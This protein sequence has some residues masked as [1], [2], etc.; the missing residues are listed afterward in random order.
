LNISSSIESQDISRN[1]DFNKYQ[2]YMSILKNNNS[3]KSSNRNRYNSFRNLIY[4]S[5]SLETQT[6]I[7]IENRKK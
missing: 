2:K 4:N 5:S 3:L 7:D 6:K 1:K